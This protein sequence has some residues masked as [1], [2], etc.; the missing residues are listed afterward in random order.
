MSV[1]K[2]IYF[3][4]RNEKA[5]KMF[6]KQY[7]NIPI[8]LIEHTCDLTKPI[9]VAIYKGQV[10]DGTVIEGQSGNQSHFVATNEIDDYD[11]YMYEQHLQPDTDFAHWYDFISHRR[12]VMID[13][14]G[15]GCGGRG[16]YDWEY[17]DWKATN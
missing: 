15:N 9:I 1:S 4:P 11:K 10:K 5:I 12:F 17:L 6:E 3:N 8:S 14:K 16:G 2:L 7:P 13:S